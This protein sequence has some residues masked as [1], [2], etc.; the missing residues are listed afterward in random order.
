MKVSI[1]LIIMQYNILN[2]SIYVFCK[3][4]EVYNVYYGDW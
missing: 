2:G 1:T 3:R 4:L